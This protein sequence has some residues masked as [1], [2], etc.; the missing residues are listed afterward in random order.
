MHASVGTRLAS[1]VCETEIIVIR[2]PADDV[3]LECGG[4]LMVT[5]GSPEA[6]GGALEA[7]EEG[8]GT[9]VG[10]RYV[11]S[12]HQLEVLCTKSGRGSLRAGGSL[13]TIRPPA[14]LPS[15]D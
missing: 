15:S 3:D 10:K 9:L 7:S 8:E 12:G 13:L 5:A 1:T 2:A 4:A 11:D 14:N 6:H